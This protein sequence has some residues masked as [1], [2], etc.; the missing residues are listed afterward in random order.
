[1]ITSDP[2]QLALRLGLAAAL[3]VFMGLAFEETYK[4]E[5]RSTPGGIRSFPMLALGGA[6]L[7]LIEP[8]YA[9]AFTAGLL[10]LAV[11]LYA[12]LRTARE[13]DSTIMIPASNLI[14]YALGPMGLTQPTW[15][16]VAVATVA[17]LLL[18]WRER[19]H[20][21]TKQLPKDE[22]LTA[23]KF[24]IL[25]GVV[26]PLVPNQPLVDFVP[27]TPYQV[28]LAVV[29]VCSL[30]YT[31]YLIQKYVPFRDAALLPAVFGG[32]Y[33]ST[34]TTIVLAKQ[35][36]DAGAARP[37]LQAGIVAAT[38]IM[39]VRLGI[40]ILL[41]NPS[42]ALTLTPALAGLF[43]IGA[44]LAAFAWRGR[45]KGAALGLEPTNP[46]QLPLALIFAALFI[47]ISVASVWAK[48]AFG[49]TGVFGLAALV[50]VT[51]IDPYVINVA[52]GGIHGLT[53]Q[54]LAAAVLIAASSNNVIKAVYALSFGGARTRQAAILLALLA[55]L[56]FAAAVYFAAG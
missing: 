44:A 41:F 28:W 1:M 55:V 48:S 45:E 53:S 47:V 13:P 27:L 56:G 12:A 14:A 8:H 9:V 26:L 42:L 36:R 33:S 20:L 18:G 2:L 31:S 52:Q 25:T 43:A 50:G 23:G 30:S 5:D 15:L 22:V 17:V 37:E 16:C 54:A 24:L 34:A 11:W 29:A 49:A 35:Q 39:Y 4:S 38:A 40:V 51:D 32:L 7:F 6:M 46:L 10:V 19:L 21:L 3:A